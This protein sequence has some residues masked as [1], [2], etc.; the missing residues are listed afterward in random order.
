M[1]GLMMVLGWKICFFFY[2]FFLLFYLIF[3]VY[4]FIHEYAKDLGQS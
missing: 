2:F 3:K 4:I 1:G